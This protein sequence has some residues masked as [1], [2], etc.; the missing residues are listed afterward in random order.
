MRRKMIIGGMAALLSLPLLAAPSMA[1]AANCS[2]RKATGTVLGGVG[3]A[4]LGNAVADGGGGLILGG[5]GGALVGREIGKSGCRRTTAYRSAPRR[6]ASAPPKA[7]S[8]PASY[9][10]YD[11]YGRPVSSGPA[12]YQPASYATCRTETRAYYDDRGS[13]VQRPVQI[14]DR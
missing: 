5:V 11:Q 10:Y 9:V 1:D 3:G 13:L 8:V 7:A 12:G 2:S 14:C 4:L 6:A